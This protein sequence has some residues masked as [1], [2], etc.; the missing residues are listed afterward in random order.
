MTS[1][2]ISFAYPSY[3]QS[4]YAYMLNAI[5]KKLISDDDRVYYCGPNYATR[6]GA[7]S[8]IISINEAR[9][10]LNINKGQKLILWLQDCPYS[11]YKKLINNKNAIKEGDVIL[12]AA[13]SYFGFNWKDLVDRGIKIDYLF[14]GYNEFYDLGIDFIKSKFKKENISKF[15]NINEKTKFLNNKK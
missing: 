13:P 8:I 9:D 7:S 10:K 11:K 1:K 5:T 3:S 12:F 6:H 14:Y 2:Q 4:Y 15:M